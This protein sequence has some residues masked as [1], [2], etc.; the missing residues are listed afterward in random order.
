VKPEKTIIPP[1]ES[2]SIKAIFNS[3]GYKGKQHKTITV[4]N[5][6]PGRNEVGLDNYRVLLRIIGDV[7]P[8]SN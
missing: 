2:S 1:G 4:I 6:V 8:A 3:R 7:Q 5:N